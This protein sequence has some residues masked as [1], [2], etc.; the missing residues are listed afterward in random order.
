[1]P[2]RGRA[3]RGALRRRRRRS[4]RRG[5]PRPHRHAR[6]HRAEHHRRRRR[7]RPAR[8]ARPST[9]PHGRRAPRR[10]PA[11]ALRGAGVN[12]WLAAATVLVVLLLPLAAVAVRLEAIHG[13][14]ALEIGG[15]LTAAAL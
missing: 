4:P 3:A 9:R 5:L 13:L 12:V 10:L 6:L 7:S 14:V 15:T 2:R 8:A 11:S 1:A